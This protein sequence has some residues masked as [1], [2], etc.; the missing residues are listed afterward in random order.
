MAEP[1][2]KVEHLTVGFPSKA[3]VVSAVTDVSFE[4]PSR[5]GARRRRRVGFGQVGDGAGDDAAAPEVDADHRL[6]PVRRHTTS[7][8]LS[9]EEMRRTSGV[10][11]IAM[12]FQ[13][14]MTALNPVF[15]VGDQIVEAM[16]AST[17]TCRK[18]QAWKRADRAARPG[19][20]SRA[21][22]RVHRSTRTSSP[23]ACGSGR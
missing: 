4:H 15:T 23:A 16:P 12:I 20:R 7:S 2:L 13:D 1:L 14:P 5:R 21:G 22:Q 18:E 3:G 9:E 11:D 19:R 10:S 17:T 8:A 6:G